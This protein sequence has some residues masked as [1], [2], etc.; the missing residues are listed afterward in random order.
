MTRPT[1]H[2]RLLLL[3]LCALASGGNTC[4]I[5]AEPA[6]AARLFMGRQIAQTM[7]YT[8]APWLVRESRE[9]EEECGTLLKSLR[10]RPGQTVCDIGCGNGF[11]TLR[12]ARMVGEQGAVLAVDIQPE[13]LDLLRFRAREAKIANV[14][15]ILGTA[16]DPHL[17]A[18]TVDLVLLVDVYH[19]MSHPAA[20]LRAIR[21]SL[22]PDGR[23]VLVEFRAEDP[24]VPIK[25][26]HKMSKRQILKEIP[27]HGFRLTRQ[28]DDL[29][30]QHVMFFQP[31]PLAGD[32]PTGDRP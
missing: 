30:W 15:P 18:G 26:L 24:R 3:T 23:M 31:E 21:N 25:P 17:P 7:H 16:T 9:R 14:V 12:L 22:K 1:A 2:L 11:Y 10:I 4:L 28:F 27:P 13:M 19:E 20:M 6:A 8:G 5:A 32:E 29:P